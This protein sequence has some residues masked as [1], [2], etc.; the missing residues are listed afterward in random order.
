MPSVRT[1][2]IGTPKTEEA[3]LHVVHAIHY[4]PNGDLEETPD[5]DG[6]HHCRA[7]E[8]ARLWH[9][10][11]GSH[12]RGA[13]LPCLYQEPERQHLEN[14]GVT[15]RRKETRMESTV[16][17]VPVPGW[18]WSILGD[19]HHGRVLRVPVDQTLDKAYLL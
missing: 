18:P 6:E 15:H 7:A 9:R 19:I 2:H 14:H 16:G 12:H 1:L 11:A 3:F 10:P 8:S 17:N 4:N 5:E 13:D